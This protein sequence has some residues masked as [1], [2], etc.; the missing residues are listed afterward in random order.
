MLAA[1][2]VFCLKNKKLPIWVSVNRGRHPVAKTE[3][4][5]TYG[6]QDLG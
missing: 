5:D 6:M 1:L 4:A 2:T 3:I